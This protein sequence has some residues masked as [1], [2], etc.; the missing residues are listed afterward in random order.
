MAPRAASWLQ[1]L[2]SRSTPGWAPAR[3]AARNPTKVQAQQ[4]SLAL[5]RRE[6]TP[7]SGQAAAVQ[8]PGVAVAVTPLAEVP[9]ASARRRE[10]HPKPA[11]AAPVSHPSWVLPAAPRAALRQ[12]RQAAV[13]ASKAAGQEARPMSVRRAG[14]VQA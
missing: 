12:V 10:A 2:P 3:R 11:Q 1:R 9:A 5:P 8:Q 4:M 7:M 6:A 13:V 14:W